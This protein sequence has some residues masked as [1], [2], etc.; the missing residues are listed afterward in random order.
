MANF[1]KHTS[2][3]KCGSSDAKGLYDDG[4]S[5]CFSCHSGSAGALSQRLARSKA[6]DDETPRNRALPDDVCS[7]FSPSAV[8][9]LTST[10]LDLGTLIKHGVKWSPSKQQIIFTWPGLDLWQAR[11]M[12]P[13]A[14]VRY[15]TSGNHE[16][17]FPFYIADSVDSRGLVLVED[18]LSA[19]KIA[20]SPYNYDSMPLLGSSISANKL[21]KL[22]QMYSTVLVWLD[23]DKGKEAL[24]ISV[25]LKML[26]IKTRVIFTEDDPKYISHD[27]MKRY[28]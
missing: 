8:E 17:D 4:S 11:N 3:E 5:W 20:T 6:D 16:K 12:Y 25:K 10:G 27:E 14:K 23:H 22:K 24:K 7:H 9:W 26:G 19:I 1:L 18:C 28:L 15:I 13:D 2:C 21:Q